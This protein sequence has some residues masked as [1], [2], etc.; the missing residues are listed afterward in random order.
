MLV[1]AI[2]YNISQVDPK[3]VFLLAEATICMLKNILTKLISRNKFKNKLR[4]LSVYDNYRSKNITDR[5][6]LEKQ[7]ERLNRNIMSEFNLD[8]GL[9]NKIKNNDFNADTDMIESDEENKEEKNKTTTENYKD[10]NELT[11]LNNI[12]YDLN[13]QFIVPVKKQKITLYDL[14]NLLEIS[15]SSLMP[16]H[17]IYT[18]NMEKTICSMWHESDDSDSTEE[19]LV[20][21]PSQQLH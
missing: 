14:K 5:R 1:S 12:S 19:E 10:E 11:E 2:D 21:Q 16:S 17:S 8:S 9:L 13:N 4:C 20:T 6:I 3:A 7:N 18:I 15:K